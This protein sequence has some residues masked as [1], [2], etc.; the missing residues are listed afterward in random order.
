M[1]FRPKT[2]KEL[3]QSRLLPDCD[4]PFEVI[5]ASDATSK[6][7]NP[8]IKLKLNVFGPNDR[9]VHIYDYISDAF[10]EHKLRHFCF[11]V[12]LGA[13]YESGTLTARQCLGRQ[14]YAHIVLEDGKDGF[15]DKNVAFDYIVPES[16]VPPAAPEEP[17]ATTNTEVPVDPVIPASSPVT[18]ATDAQL[19]GEV[20]NDDV[21]F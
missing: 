6:G 7:G 8:M 1:N 4:A 2:E 12:G 5:E 19:R 20:P 13:A 3:E 16:E 15:R 9:Q 11:C 18:T 14:G 21:P 10:M 17:P